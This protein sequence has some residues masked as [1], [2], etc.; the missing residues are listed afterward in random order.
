MGHYSY[1]KAA[2]GVGILNQPMEVS[3]R[4]ITMLAA[5]L[6]QM[7]RSLV[8]DHNVPEDIAV[9]LTLGWYQMTILCQQ[10]GDHGCMQ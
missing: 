6:A 4:S 5:F 3:E 10:E 9:E 2:E 7:Y 8:E 1:G